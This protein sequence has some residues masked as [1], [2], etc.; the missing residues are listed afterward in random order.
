MFYVF[1][2]T[3]YQHIRKSN[4][5]YAKSTVIGLNQESG[6]MVKWDTSTRSCA[7]VGSHGKRTNRRNDVNMTR[8]C[9]I[10]KSFLK[11]QLIK[12]ERVSNLIICA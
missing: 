5:S 3:H 7:V 6:H 12:L 1:E 8:D 9:H 4:E 11:W 2:P 10:G